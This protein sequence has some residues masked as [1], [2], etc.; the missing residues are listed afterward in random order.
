MVRPT[1]RMRTQNH[2]AA[3]IIGKDEQQVGLDPRSDTER[4]LAVLPVDFDPP[5]LWKRESRPGE[6][7]LISFLEPC[8][9]PRRT[10]DIVH[11]DGQGM[12]SERRIRG[13]VEAARKWLSDDRRLG[14]TPD[15][16]E[17]ENDRQ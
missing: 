17:R 1:L 3:A 11:A 16:D 2:Y 10:S 6:N 15:P 12:R 13:Q 5:H 8:A 9:P 4:T 14:R 7:D